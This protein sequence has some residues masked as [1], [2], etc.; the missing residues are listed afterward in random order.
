MV[1]PGP[2]EDSDTDLSESERCLEYSSCRVPPHLELRSEVIEDEESISYRARGRDRG[3]LAFPDFLP[4]PF[5]SWNLSQLAVFYNMEGRAA[6]WPR[7]NSPLERY[8]QKL[9]QLEWHQL[10]TI[11]EERGQL[12]VSEVTSSC[13]RSVVSRLSSPKCILQCQRAF[14][15]TFL[16]PLVSHPTLLS[17]CAYTPCSTCSYARR[18]ACCRESRLSP[19]RQS[20]VVT[21]VTKRSCSENRVHSSDRI[22]GSQ[23]LS[24]PS[25]TSI[26]LRRMQ[27]SGNIRNPVQGAASRSLS[28]APKSRGHSEEGHMLDCSTGEFRRRSGSEQRVSGPKRQQNRSENRQSSSECRKGRAEQRRAADLKNK[29]VKLDAVPAILVKFPRSKHSQITGLSRS[30][31]VEFVL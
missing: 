1:S 30:K 11:Q 14:P 27:A 10:Q 2:P 15:L 22:P 13:P 12:H 19:P 9:L 18:V 7:S 17:S 3:R 24:S 29:Q 23:R 21:S 20:R 6:P 31:A 4:P 28:A 25:R 26:Y 8:L 16:S 5:N